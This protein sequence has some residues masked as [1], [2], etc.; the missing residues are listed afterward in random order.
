[1]GG[2]V[3]FSDI[4]NWQQQQPIQPASYTC[5]Y[6]GNQV[7]SNQGYYAVTGAAMGPGCIRLCPS[8][9]MPTVFSHTGESFPTS[10]PGKPVANVP[11]PLAKLYEEARLSAGAG[12]HTAAVLICRKMLMNIAVAEGADEGKRFVQYVE[13]LADKG[14]VPPNGRV[15]VDYIRTRGNE[16]THEIALMSQEDAVA[17][18]TFV[19]M[20]LR[21][22]YEF[23]NM[24]PATVVV[25]STDG[26]TS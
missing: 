5:G 23:P 9:Q 21:F 12:A 2:K 19:E 25:Q 17:L 1:M 3:F 8:C 16:A 10:A 6:C 14:F 20:L 15:W 24:V 22:I 11:E 18:V 26:G 13:Y 4:S 7:A